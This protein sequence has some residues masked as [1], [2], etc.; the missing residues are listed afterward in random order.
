MPDIPYYVIGLS[1]SVILLA[2]I[3][4]FWKRKKSGK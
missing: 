3:V 1:I 2:G 4:V